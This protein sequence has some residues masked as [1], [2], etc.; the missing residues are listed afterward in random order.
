VLEAS[1]E[2]MGEAA[3]IRVAYLLSVARPEMAKKLSV[4]VIYLS[5]IQAV[6]MT[7]MLYMVVKNIIILLTTDPTMQ[8]MMNNAIGLIGLA[9]VS[10]AFARISWSL[11]GA[12]GRFRL[13]TLII[14]V[15]RWFVTT[16]IALISVFAFKL[17]LN[18]VSGALVVGYATASCA[19]AYCVLRS[20]WGRLA[21]SMQEM[22][23]ILDE[24]DSEQSSSYHEDD[25]SYDEL[26]IKPRVHDY[27]S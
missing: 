26:G 15:S 1:T 17:D 9:N 11:T 7:S 14:F 16:P 2:G 25:V 6:L 21:R 18:S 22:N 8:H 5:L 24:N 19:L 27:A 23:T 20:D 10:L 13:A 12:Q 3:A 4:K